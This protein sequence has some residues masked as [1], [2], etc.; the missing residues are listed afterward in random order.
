[1]GEGDVADVEPKLLPRLEAGSKEPV[2]SLPSPENVGLFED[3]PG[4]IWAAFLG[5]WALFFGLIIVFFA[6]SPTATFMV[7]VAALFGLIAFGLPITLAA[8]LNCTGVKCTGT[9]LTHTGPLSERAAAA[10]IALIPVA[11]VIGLIGFI[12]L[13]M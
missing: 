1:L 4:R 2:A 6:T 9:I 13:A 12:V 10:Q 11:V 3:I 8:Q 5:A 7:V